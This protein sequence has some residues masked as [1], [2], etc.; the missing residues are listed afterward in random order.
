MRKI[1]STYADLL[2]GPVHGLGSIDAVRSD[3]YLMGQALLELTGKSSAASSQAA[4]GVVENSRQDFLTNLNSAMG[5]LPDQIDKLADISNEWQTAIYG[6]CGM[7]T[8]GA[9]STNPAIKAKAVETMTASCSPALG[10]IAKQLVGIEQAVT[11]RMLSANT[12]ARAITHD[13]VIKMSAMVGSGLLLTLVAAFLLVRYGIARPL[14]SLGDAMTRL[15]DRDLSVEIPGQTRGDE[16]GHISRIVAIFKN[17]AL[18][19]RDLEQRER[20][21]VAARERRAHAIESLTSTFDA[22][23]ASILETVSG[24]GIELEETAQTMSRSADQTN[25]QAMTVASATHQAA[26]SVETAAAAAEQLSASIKEIGRQVE[27]SSRIS[28]SASEEAGRTNH[29]VLGLA[30]TSQ[31]IG[32][33]I[34][35]INDI[36][37]QTNLLALNATIEAA[38]AGDAGKGFAVVAGEVKSL[39]TQTAKATDEIASQISAVQGATQDAVEAIQAIVHRIE[40]INHI[41]TAISA[42]VEQQSAATQE[43]ARNV[44]EA[45]SG[46]QQVSET[47][48]G[49][50]DAAETTGSA[51]RHVLTSAQSL[52]GNADMLKQVVG[53]FLQGVRTL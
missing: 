20:D 17:N 4:M 48:G 19:Q 44:Q 43:I 35:L 38:R 14:F 24:A 2:H 21:E 15:A 33:V 23:V 1:D 32:E 11:V 29:T 22:K 36:A 47:I 45:S 26:A 6:P 34:N 49:V 37:N 40:E 3:V 16:I 5:M 27:Q 30:E 12:H 10:Q 8:A 18:A 51:S 7:V 13:A 52:A 53:D 28:A 42:A 39:A 31:R 46:T 50:R 41:A 9:Q 25:R